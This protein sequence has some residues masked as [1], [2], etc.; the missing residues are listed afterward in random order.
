MPERA[1]FEQMY[2]T[3]RRLSRGCRRGVPVSVLEE[4]RAGG[5]SGTA[6]RDGP[7]SGGRRPPAG[8]GR[9]GGRGAGGGRR[10]GSG[11]GGGGRAAGRRARRRGRAPGL[12]AQLG[13]QGGPRLRPAVA[14]RRP[15]AA[16]PSGRRGPAPSASPPPCSRASTDQL[17][18]ALAPPRSRSGSPPPRSRRTASGPAACPGSPA[19]VARASAAAGS[20]AVADR[21]RR[22]A[23]PAPPPGRP[24][25]SSRAWLGQPGAGR[26]RVRRRRPPGRRRQVLDGVGEVEHAHRVGAVQVEEALAPPRP[27]ADPDHRPRRLRPPRRWVSTSASRAKAAWSARRRS[28]R[29]SVARR[30]PVAPRLHRPDGQ[31]LD[32]APLAA[33]QRH[34][35]PV[36]RSPAAR[37]APPAAPA[38]P[39][40]AAR[41]RPSAAAT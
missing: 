10:A 19:A 20:G 12:G 1:A 4:G 21:Q 24:C 33:D 32:L 18:G 25:R 39:A 36:D 29:A 37:P 15:S 23:P 8:A 5:R 14:A 17:V 34:H 31:R 2:Y 13:G 28:T 6:A 38:P 22:A 30:L 11:A 27:V 26:R 40:P 35:R 9:R 7:P 3:S 16:P 41:P